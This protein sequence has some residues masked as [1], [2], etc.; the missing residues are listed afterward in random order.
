[1]AEVSEP[2]SNAVTL[3]R[4]SKYDVFGATRSGTG[5]IAAQHKYVGGLGHTVDAY[6]SFIYMRAR[7]M[8]PVMGRK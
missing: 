1:V 8:D 6:I 2:V 7:W 4:T 5:S 3:T